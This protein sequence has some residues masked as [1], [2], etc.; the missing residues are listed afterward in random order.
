VTIQARMKA[1]SHSWWF[2]KT[3]ETFNTFIRLSK[4]DK[5]G[6]CICVTCGARIMTKDSNA[7]HYMHGLNFVEDNQNIQ[8]R[9]CNLFLSGNLAQYA[10]YMI[11]KYGRERVDELHSE[12]MK[13]HKYGIIELREIRE[14][15]KQKIK[16]LEEGKDL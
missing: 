11:D 13:P 16:E 1:H 9:R 15:Y 12:K 14:K 8:C 10:L 5:N 2:K 3:K 4:S 7:G 6:M